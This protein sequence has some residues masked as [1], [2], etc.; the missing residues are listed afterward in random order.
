[1]RAYVGKG[2]MSAAFG[3]RLR[4]LAPCALPPPSLLLHP[5]LQQFERILYCKQRPEGGSKLTKRCDSW[6][7]ALGSG[8][9]LWGPDAAQSMHALHLYSA[10]NFPAM[11]HRAFSTQPSGAQDRK[12]KT[13]ER[14][15]RG[16]RERAR[17]AWTRAADD[18]VE[19]DTE[20]VL[21]LIQSRDE[22]SG[23][24]LSLEEHHVYHMSFTMH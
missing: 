3:P 23:A 22:A 17:G 24:R 9:S 7:K 16:G 5:L 6:A 18:T 13:T 2:R 12:Q 21:D 19:I 1:M 15:V 20:M 11:L 14:G 8:T 4:R 10:Q